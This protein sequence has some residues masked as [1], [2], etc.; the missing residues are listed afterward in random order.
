MKSYET[1]PILRGSA[2]EQLQLLRSYLYRL[3]LALTEARTQMEMGEVPE[4]MKARLVKAAAG[5]TA[6]KMESS[7]AALKAL[8]LKTAD[9]VER[10]MEEIERTLHGE[11]VAKSEF[12][13]FSEEMSGRYTMTAADVTALYDI[14]TNLQSGAQETE[15]ELQSYISRTQGF[16]RA[17]VVEYDGATP[18]LG[19]AIGQ[20]I[21]V[22]GTETVDGQEVEVIRTANLTTWTPEKMTFYQNGTAVAY[23]SNEKLYVTGAR[24]KGQLELGAKWEVSH[25]NGFTVKW[26]G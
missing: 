26:I 7:S 19:I 18:V 23:L 25:Q 10:Q 12:G 21:A 22:S 4:G 2:T 3:S 24:I 14:C 16:L 1:P 6:Q 20:N 11:Y 13:T 17:G 5:E 8:I 9:T 15:S